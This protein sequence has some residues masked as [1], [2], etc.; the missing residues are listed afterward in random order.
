MRNIK[1]D[2]RKTRKEKK[3]ISTGKYQAYLMVRETAGRARIFENKKKKKKK[4]IIYK[5]R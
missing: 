4:K 3:N 2:Y 5:Y 1:R